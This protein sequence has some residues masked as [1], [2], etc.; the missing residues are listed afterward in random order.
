MVIRSEEMEI[1]KIPWVAN[2]GIKKDCP[3]CGTLMI[4]DDWQIQVGWRLDCPPD[5]ISG[6]EDINGI[7]LC[8]TCAVI[9]IRR[10]F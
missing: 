10:L 2:N 3:V 4:A 8:Q 7:I 1:R 6:A 9:A 5:D